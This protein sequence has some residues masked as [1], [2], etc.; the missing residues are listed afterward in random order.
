MKQQPLRSYGLSRDFQ[1]QTEL[2]R[3]GGDQQISKCI[4][5]VFDTLN[6]DNPLCINIVDSVMKRKLELERSTADYNEGEVEDK[7]EDEVDI[8]DDDDE[9]FGKKGKQF[10]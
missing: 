10:E 2:R 6:P 3:R 8:D 5:K 1:K 9:E 7:I 4:D